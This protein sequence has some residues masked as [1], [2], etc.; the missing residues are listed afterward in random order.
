MRKI[1]FIV[2]A[3]ALVTS[4]QVFGQA[5]LPGDE[6]GPRESPE[7]RRCPDG[8]IKTVCE[9]HDYLGCGDIKGCA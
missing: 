1:A 5:S 2:L 7:Q 6:G 8:K 9:P 3:F 4:S